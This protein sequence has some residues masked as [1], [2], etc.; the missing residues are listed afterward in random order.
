MAHTVRHHCDLDVGRPLNE[1]GVPTT[2]F[3]I[4]A[5]CLIV[6]V[7]DNCK[8]ML[9]HLDNV[10]RIRIKGGLRFIYCLYKDAVNLGL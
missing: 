5:V 6:Y 4:W 2:N 3:I 1:F 7:I 9:G 8:S 10:N